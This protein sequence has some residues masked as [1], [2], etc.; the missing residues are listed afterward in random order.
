MNL[1][2]TTFN[3]SYPTG[4]KCIYTP[5]KQFECCLSGQ[6]SPCWQIH[7]FRHVSEFLLYIPCKVGVFYVWKT[8][9]LL[10]N[11]EFYFI[12]GVDK[13]INLNFIIKNCWKF[14]VEKNVVGETANGVPKA[15]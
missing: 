9:K 11:E 6:E 14:V 1:Y 13:F 5:M 8:W 4:N 12:I 10:T 7:H 2:K 3:Q 15:L